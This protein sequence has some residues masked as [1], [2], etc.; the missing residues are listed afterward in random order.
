MVMQLKTEIPPRDI[1]SIFRDIY[2]MAKK[3]QA[4]TEVDKDEP[5]MLI[6]D[7][8]RLGQASAIAQLINDKYGFEFDYRLEF[9]PSGQ[10][11]R[12]KILSL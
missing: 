1:A 2:F 4:D 6:I 7:Y 3:Y 11:L 10:Q 5:D 8:P 9:Y 12:F